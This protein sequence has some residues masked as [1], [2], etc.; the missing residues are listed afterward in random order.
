MSSSNN[1]TLVTKDAVFMMR[2]QLN[3]SHCS[4][5]HLTKSRIKIMTERLRINLDMIKL[6]N[7]F[8]G[9]QMASNDPNQ[10]KDSLSLLAEQEDDQSQGASQSQ[11]ESSTQ[12]SQGWKCS[13]CPRSFKHEKT[14]LN[15]VAKKHGID[16]SLNEDSFAPSRSSTHESAVGMEEDKG[17]REKERKRKREDDEDSE[18][19]ERPR[20]RM[21]TIDEEEEVLDERILDDTFDRDGVRSSTQG[22][23][24]EMAEVFQG[25]ERVMVDTEGGEG[26]DDSMDRANDKALDE[27]ERKLKLKDDLLHNKD[28][29]L[30]QREAE[31]AEARELKDQKDRILRKAH[32][33]LKEKQ[34]EI[35]QM[36]KRLAEK[37]KVDFAKRAESP[38]KAKL[39]ADLEKAATT[40]KCLTGKAENIKKDLEIAKRAIRK[41]DYDADTYKKVEASLERTLLKLADVEKELDH[42]VKE[43]AIL[44]KK[45]PCTREGCEWG[46][47]C[48][49][50]HLLKYED[51]SEPKDP[52]WKRKILCRFFMTGGCRET[53]ERCRFLHQRPSEDR[54]RDDEVFTENEASFT[55]FMNQRHRRFR[56]SGSLDSSVEVLEE[57]RRSMSREMPKV[58]MPN[59]KGFQDIRSKNGQPQHKRMRTEE[60]ELDSNGI[61]GMSLPKSGNGMGAEARS[62]HSVPVNYQRP[63]Q[64][65][66]TLTMRMEA[67]RRSVE[68]GMGGRA[69]P[70][71][72]RNWSPIR[73][74]EELDRSRPRDR[75]LREE[76]VE[77]RNGRGMRGSMRGAMR[78]QARERTWS[79]NN[80]QE[81]KDQDQQYHQQG[82]RYNYGRK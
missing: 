35:E 22:V 2:P 43:R 14:L 51:R 72:E 13:K 50:S 31:L 56:E 15:H 74:P 49:N 12:P 77:R 37:N 26:L 58:Q 73:S 1:A 44:M 30:A 32:A 59:G 46:R 40:I 7:N 65:E 60:G 42:H 70:S 4:G 9:F 21:G 41:H 45:I 24:H 81:E 3:D 61:R 55:G 68:S 79:M 78:G 10:D 11:D 16:E 27:L 63:N 48:S 17:E 28:A 67:G 53:A 34:K 33:E 54:A 20:H 19:D 23:L 62:R 38:T 71:R 69:G 36:K 6:C 29:K 25:A 57:R 52:N 82:R 8:E 18:E 75:D 64:R 39:K 47:D 76:M 5:L 80:N 66:P